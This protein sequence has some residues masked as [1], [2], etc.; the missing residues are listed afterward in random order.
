MLAAIAL[1]CLIGFTVAA[2][3]GAAALSGLVEAVRTRRAR[4]IAVGDK[5]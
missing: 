3:V 2:F 1:L 5:R 4:R